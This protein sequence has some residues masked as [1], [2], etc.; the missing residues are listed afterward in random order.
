MKNRFAFAAFLGAATLCAS[1]RTTA[2]SF[3]GFTEPYRKIE[4][5]A[6]ETGTVERLLVREGDHVAKGQTLATLDSEVL[7]VS[8]EIATANDQARGKLNYAQ[9]ERDL[10]KTR[11]ERLGPLR[12]QGHASQEEIDRAQTELAAAEANLLSAREQHLLDGLER[13]KIQAMIER[14]A[15]RSP[16]DGV[17][18]RIHKDEQEFVS[19]NSAAVATVVQLDPLRVVFTVPT[20][21]AMSVKV[22]QVVALEFP[23]SGNKAS[24]KIELV[25]PVTEAESGTVRVKV[26]MDNPKGEHR[27]GVRCSLDLQGFTPDGKSQKAMTAGSSQLH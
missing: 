5:A 8:K 21:H 13:K 1:V 17:V 12:Q 10:R 25:A 20:A 9:A 23:E 4:V 7:V 16:I 19:N 22:G 11:L 27:C 3:E 15:V 14:R 26:I 24:G 6:A 2:T 18:T